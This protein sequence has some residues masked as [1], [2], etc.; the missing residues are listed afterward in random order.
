MKKC[1]HPEACDR[2]TRGRRWCNMHQKR[3]NNSPTGDP[4]PVGPVYVAT[5]KYS[6]ET[7]ARNDGRVCA[8][9]PCQRETEWA[10]TG[11]YCRKHSQRNRLNGDPGIVNGR[12]HE[13]CDCH[14]CLERPLGKSWC[15][16]GEHYVDESDYFRGQSECRDCSRYRFYE[17]RYG[18]N[19]DDVNAALRYLEWTCPIGREDLREVRWVIDHDHH[20]QCGCG[21]SGG[22]ESCMR[23]ILC[24]AC[25]KLIGRFGDDPM[26]LRRMAQKPNGYPDGW[27][28]AAADYLERWRQPNLVDSTTRWLT[29]ILTEVLGRPLD[30]TA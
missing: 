27:L 25:N 29:D 18:L 5:G 24:D 16:Y 15:K 28:L 30:E 23:A 6:Y 3:I 8:Y 4:G 12:H 26:I 10:T 9:H 22:C 14:I 13:D 21:P 1:A 7:K 17:R 2:E 11:V 20:G 19:R